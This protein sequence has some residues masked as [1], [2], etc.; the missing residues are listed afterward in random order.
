MF[1]S[2]AAIPPFSQLLTMN[3]LSCSG[4][5]L[6]HI[7][8]RGLYWLCPDCRQELPLGDRSPLTQVS[9]LSAQNNQESLISS[10]QQH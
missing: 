7:R 9:S 8:K 10:N 1:S 5:M 2:I 6:Q 3:C 4:K